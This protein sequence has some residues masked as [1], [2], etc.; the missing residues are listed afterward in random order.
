MKILITGI[1]GGLARRVAL[2]LLR[3]GH[4]ILGLDRRPWPDAPPEVTLLR[5]DMRKRPAEEFIR[6]HRPDAL[7]H[8]ATVTF[9]TAPP[10]ERYRINLGGTKALYSYCQRYQVKKVIFVGR[11]T[12]YG[13][14]PDV[15]LYRSEEDPPLATATYPELADMVAADLFAASALWRYP[16]LESAVLRLVYTLG[17]SQRGT[18]AGFLGSQEGGRVPM[19]LGFDPLFQLM[20]EGDAVDAICLALTRQLTG[21]YNVAGPPPIPLSALCRFAG[22]RPLSVPEPLLPLALSRFRRAPLPARAINHLKYPVV[23]DDQLFR[24]A[25]GFQ[26]RYD[27]LQTVAAFRE[28]GLYSH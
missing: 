23:V 10:E 15:S 1:S 4:E 14:A 18:L 28:E 7:I 16:E 6:V 19:V 2:Q 22:R 17:P 8:L 24:A 13:A 9:R 3:A 12:V 27:L 26:S 21:I 5:A 11:H 20:H 25:T